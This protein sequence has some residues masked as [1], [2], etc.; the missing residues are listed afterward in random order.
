[1]ETGSIEGEGE[2]W[3]KMKKHECRPRSAKGDCIIPLLIDLYICQKR[4][5]DTA[6]GVYGAQNEIMKPTS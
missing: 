4:N 1:M 5:T 3:N 2:K 6:G